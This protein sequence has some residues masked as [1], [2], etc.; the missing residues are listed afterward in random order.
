MTKSENYKE[1][2]DQKKEFYRQ[3]LQRDSVKDFENEFVR[4]TNLETAI[5]NEYGFEGIK[6]L[7]ENRNSENY[8]MLGNFPTGCP[9]SALNDE[10]HT[11]FIESNFKSIEH[12]IPNLIQSIQNR[13]KFIY[14]EKKEQTWNL[15]YFLDMKLYD[16]REY[17]RIY[18]GG[19]PN[20]TAAPNENLKLF[21]WVIP[22]D[23]EQFYSIYDGF[24]EFDGT[25]IQSS[26]DIRVMA[27]MMNPICKEQDFDF[28]E[29]YKFEDLLEFCPDGAG[30]AQ[31]FYRKYS[32]G[33]DSQT[34]DWDH[35]IWE[36]SDEINFFEFIDERMSA[37][38]EE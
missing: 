27:E 5:I 7:F 38:D 13:C 21:D 37:I 10:N 6:L 23:L 12:K 33:L 32:D 2:S 22:K 8:F 15:H 4:T 1:I 34:V 31:C 29:E 14:V 28:P 35:E 9:W 18:T 16:G 11:Q 26:S 24:G 20:P 25:F 19:S 36:I 30:N 17:F 3:L